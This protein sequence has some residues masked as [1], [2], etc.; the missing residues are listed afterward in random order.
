[1]NEFIGF[2]EAIVLAIALIALAGILGKAAS[3]FSSHKDK[4]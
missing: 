3:Y 2:S 1:M 4:N